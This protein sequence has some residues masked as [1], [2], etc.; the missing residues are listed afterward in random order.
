MKNSIC[1]H[2]LFSGLSAD[3]KKQLRRRSFAAVIVFL[4]GSFS[5]F[6]LVCELSNMTGSIACNCT[7]QAIAELR[8]M[9][10]V[11]FPAIV[12]LCLN[13]F[14]FD[15]YRARTPEKRNTL[16][17]R[18][19]TATVVFGAVIVLYVLYGYVS[20][21]Y[22]R[23]IEGC[24]SPLYPLDVLVGGV[25]FAVLGA[26]MR[27]ASEKPRTGEAFVSCAVGHGFRVFHVYGTMVALFSFA[28]CV[29]GSYGMDWSHGGIWFNISTL[30][31]YFSAFAMAAVYR[32]VYCELLP[33]Y[34]RKAQ[35]RLSAAFL[36]VNLLLFAVYVITVNANSELP[37]QNAFCILPI[38]YFAS[39]NAFLLLLCSW[40]LLAP[41]VA[42]IK[43]LCTK[44]AAK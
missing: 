26:G 20:G 10:P 41:A 25:L 9:F 34:R 8:R 24:P 23:L 14:A 33:A 43:G 17:K 7:A 44:A 27:R 2:F 30:L 3:G 32:F 16:L 40:D 31:L 21:E 39:K 6:E 1:E 38:D 35:L 28:A 42:L 36:L 19:G 11:I 4:L 15:L 13:V 37:N 29:Y 5:M 12:Y 18:N 22:A